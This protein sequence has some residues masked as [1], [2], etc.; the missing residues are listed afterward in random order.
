MRREIVIFAVILALVLGVGLFGRSLIT[1]IAV[2]EIKEMFPGY[3][4]SIGAAEIRNADMIAITGI[5]AENGKGVSYKIN[6]LEV[7][8][9]PF[10]LFTRKVP[11]IFVKSLN[12][13]IISPEKKFKDAVGY[14]VFK[15]GKSFT[16]KSVTVLS[17]GMTVDTADWKLNA[18][19]DG[20]IE[21]R[22]APSGGTE[23]EGNF[24][25]VQRGG[26]IAI[27]DEAFLK[28]LAEGSNQPPAAVEDLKD[29]N[30]KECTLQISGKT[31]S[32]VFHITLEGAKGRKDLTF[33]LRGL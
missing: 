32:P 15:P 20:N 21:T 11:K 6:S 33:P 25:T 5:K 13:E 1:G 17:F 19:C 3:N 10:S 16:A 22:K 8:F 30:F 28:R 29:Y 12:L 4:V 9:S 31:G 14:P 23:I 2:K 18:L 24:S 27:K 26:N 7:K